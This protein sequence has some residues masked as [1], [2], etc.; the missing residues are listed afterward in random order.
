[1]LK[2]SYTEY[3][4]NINFKNS[5]GGGGGKNPGVSPHLYKTVVTA[6]VQTHSYIPLHSFCYACCSIRCFNMKH[7]IQIMLQ[8][9]NHVTHTCNMQRQYLPVP[10]GVFRI[11]FWPKLKLAFC[12]FSTEGSKRFGFSG[13][14]KAARF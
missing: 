8:Y 13:V 6:Y 10:V 14:L 4:K 9:T 12:G 1:M 2:I 5:G 3:S 11:Y 7:R